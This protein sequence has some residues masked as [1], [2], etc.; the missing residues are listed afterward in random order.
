M[1]LGGQDQNFVA[2]LVLKVIMCNMITYDI[3]TYK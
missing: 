2:Y 3:L 1:K